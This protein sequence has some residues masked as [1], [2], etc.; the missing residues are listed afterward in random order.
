[1]LVRHV[2][3]GVGER[4]LVGRRPGDVLMEEIASGGHPLSGGEAGIEERETGC[5]RGSRMKNAHRIAAGVRCVPLGGPMRYLVL[6][7]ALLSAN[8][9]AAK[10]YLMN[11]RVET[12]VT[13]K[14]VYVC[15][16]RYGSQDF[17]R[18]IPISER[19]PQSIEV[20]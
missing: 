18:V 11:T 12:S 8:A 10:A 4:V 19:C 9:Y 5:H 16:Y 6:V 7:V 13:G 20:Q 3:I 1:M 17:E 15:I 14:R 2:P